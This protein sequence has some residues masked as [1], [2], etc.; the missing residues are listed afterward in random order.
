MY[1]YA[2]VN[3]TTN[4]Y[5]NYNDKFKFNYFQMIKKHC[6]ED[7]YLYIN[8]KGELLYFSKVKT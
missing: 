7:K 5:Y 6:I 3:L 8:D 2:Y 4:V 1:D